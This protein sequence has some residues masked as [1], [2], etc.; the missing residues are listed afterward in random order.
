MIDLAATNDPSL[1]ALLAAHPRVAEVCQGSAP[2]E[3]RTGGWHR[4]IAVGDA[5]IEQHGLVELM[6]NNPIVCADAMSVPSPAATLA[7]I[8]L[9]PLAAAGLILEPPAFQTNAPGGEAAIGDFLASA[10]WPG[11]VVLDHQEADLANVYAATAI[12]AIRTPEELD[13]IDDLYEE[14]FGRSFF[15]RRDEQSD[16]HVNLVRHRPNA[17]YHLRVTPDEPACLLT[18]QVMADAKGK[19]GAA[20]MVHAMNVMCGFEESLG[21]PD[22]IV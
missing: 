6:D 18:V 7:L 15:V 10:G 19:C 3:F 16:W 1:L 12:A 14:R 4:R 21:I 13:D 5:T 8:A 11:G 17:V 20:Q 9:G 2:L 22:L